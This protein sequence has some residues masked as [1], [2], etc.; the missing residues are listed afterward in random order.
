[1]TFLL[2]SQND[3]FSK[4]I[5]SSITEIEK[6]AKIHTSDFSLSKIRKTIKQFEKLS[7]ILIF[8]EDNVNITSEELSTL[9]SITG[10][11][12]AKDIL[13]LTNIKELYNLSFL[14]KDSIVYLKTKNE[15]INY[16]KQ[17][18][19]SISLNDTKRSSKKKLLEKGIPFTPDCFGTYIA[20]DKTDICNLFISGGID[21]NSRDENGTP[22]INIAVRNDNEE[23]VKKFIKL[24]ADINAVSEDRGYT[25]V[26]DAV[27]RGNLELTK[28]FIK[29]GA[30]LNTINKEGQTNLVLAVGANKTK[31]IEAL[32]KAGADPDIK[33]Q[34]GMSAYG[35]ASLF[36]KEE[37]LSILEPYHKTL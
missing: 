29:E 4:V 22:M 11:A 30:E 28:L 15:F 19:E 13:V 27:W 35:Y 37:I 34:M 12:V 36:K 5:T 2:I 33:D 24:G 10:F 20:K 9:S 17:K 18:Y 21:I 25:P 23:L 14:Q 26:M 16:I 32:A 31:I 1:M 7:L 3:I 8:K 6:N